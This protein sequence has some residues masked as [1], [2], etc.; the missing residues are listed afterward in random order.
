MASDGY[1]KAA[2]SDLDRLAIELYGKDYASLHY[3]EADRIWDL[4]TGREG[5]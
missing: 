1:P 5:P 4:F 3:S 2:W